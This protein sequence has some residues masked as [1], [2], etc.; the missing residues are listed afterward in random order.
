MVL[1]HVWSDEEEDI[2]EIKILLRRSII[3]M[4]EKGFSL[5]LY[6]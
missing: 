5:F 3:E 6:S 4:D 2:S 1:F